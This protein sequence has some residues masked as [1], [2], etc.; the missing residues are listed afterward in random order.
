MNPAP[1][2]MEQ[3]Q[4]RKL[5]ITSHPDNISLVEHFI[6]QL[7]EDFKVKE[8]VYG[9]ILVTITEAVN[10]SIHHGNRLDPTK[11]VHIL[12]RLLNPFYL[13]ITVKDEGPGFDHMA[14]PN[15]TLP[16]NWL[17]ETGRG[18]FFM[19]QLADDIAFENNGTQITLFFNI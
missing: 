2:V 1:M 14:V 15:P 17:K 19:S 6:E 9:N 16:E 10:N 12:A 11:K 7:Q 3:T 18:I 8:D 4:E 5:I 13:S